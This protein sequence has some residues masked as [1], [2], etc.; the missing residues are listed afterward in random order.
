MKKHLLACLALLT[1]SPHLWADD[2]PKHLRRSSTEVL[3]TIDPSLTSDCVV[4][5]FFD[6]YPSLSNTQDK[7][8]FRWRVRVPDGSKVN[9]FWTHEG[10][11]K[12]GLPLEGTP[13]I[14][15]EH[16]LPSSAGDLVI[17]IRAH[18]GQKQT[19]E[20][21]IYPEFPNEVP[22]I[23]SISISEAYWLP[24]WTGLQPT[25]VQP[26]RDK[27]TNWKPEGQQ[28]LMKHFV[29]VKQVISGYAIWLEFSNE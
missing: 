4:Q 19:L 26:D 29:E 9:V 11:P 22:S 16:P 2:L 12:E 8:E 24:Y 18:R 14:P 20:I 13:L 10:I 6:P 15:E 7:R 17:V 27:A 3:G 23:Q 1:T 5:S 28:L 25:L 21:S